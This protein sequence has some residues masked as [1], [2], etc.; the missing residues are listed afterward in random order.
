VTELESAV[1]DIFRVDI[2]GFGEELRGLGE[3]W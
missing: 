2:S 1:H 3:T